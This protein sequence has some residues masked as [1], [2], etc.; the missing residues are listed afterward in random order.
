MPLPILQCGTCA[1]NVRWLLSDQDIEEGRDGTRVCEAYPNGIPQGVEM[2][3]AD[4][5][6]YKEKK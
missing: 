3:V 2:G 4:C 6:R 1:N 5:I